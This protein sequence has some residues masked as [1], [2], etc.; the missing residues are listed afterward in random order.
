MLM[1]SFKVTFDV[2]SNSRNLDSTEG[3]QVLTTEQ[4]PFSS[5]LKVK[6]GE[7]KVE[8]PLF[9]VHC[10]VPSGRVKMTDCLAS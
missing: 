10:G 1:T 8:S 5:G 6:S 9:G 3:N 7:Q 4:S 2:P